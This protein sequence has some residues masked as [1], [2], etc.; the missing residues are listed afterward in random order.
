MQNLHGLMS[1][2]KV[3]HIL[4]ETLHGSMAHRKVWYNLYETFEK[5]YTEP[6]CQLLIHRFVLRML[7]YI[8]S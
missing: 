2:R 8:Y 3:G 4:C 1:H 5:I 6:I 7:Q